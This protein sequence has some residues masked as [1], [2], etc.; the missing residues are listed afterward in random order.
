MPTVTYTISAP[1][2][3]RLQKAVGQ[4]KNLMDS[5]V[6]PQRRDA[7]A[8]EVKQYGSERFT[9]LLIDV[10]QPILLAAAHAGV[11]VPVIDIQ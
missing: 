4:V 8:A 2:L 3:A 10:E 9:Q 6:P 11:V 7:T 5:Q 1:L